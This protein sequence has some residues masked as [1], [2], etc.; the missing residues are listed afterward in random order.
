MILTAVEILLAYLINN[1]MT[2]N[3]WILLFDKIEITTSKIE[4]VTDTETKVTTLKSKTSVSMSPET[5]YELKEKVRVIR[6]NF[7]L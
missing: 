6:N 7:I 2:R 3:F 4:P 1:Y 5:Y